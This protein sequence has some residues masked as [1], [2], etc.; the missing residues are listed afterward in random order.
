M[1]ILVTQKYFQNNFVVRKFLLLALIR[2]LVYIHIFIHIDRSRIY[3]TINFYPCT[4]PYIFDTWYHQIDQ[5]RIFLAVFSYNSK[6]YPIRC[7]KILVYFKGVISSPQSVIGI[8]TK[9]VWHFWSV[10]LR[11]VTSKDGIGK[12]LLTFCG[13]QI[14]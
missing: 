2:S 5:Q 11:I 3:V 7:L 10:G 1:Q 8:Y 14:C 9:Y 13:F 6:R 12:Q 4:A